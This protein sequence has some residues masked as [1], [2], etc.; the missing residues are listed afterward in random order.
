MICCNTQVHS[1]DL[2][3]PCIALETSSPCDEQFQCISCACMVVSKETKLLKCFTI[4][5]TDQSH[6][7]EIKC[8]QD[9]PFQRVPYSYLH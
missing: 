8:C 1:S 9:E 5:K 2:D 6:V 4:G 7:N 3:V